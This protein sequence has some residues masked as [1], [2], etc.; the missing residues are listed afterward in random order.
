MTGKGLCINMSKNM[1]L[2]EER[3]FYKKKFYIGNYSSRK[4]IYQKLWSLEFFESVPV[5]I[6]NLITLLVSMALLYFPQAKISSL[7]TSNIHFWKMHLIKLIFIEKKRTKD[8]VWK[9][10]LWLKKFSLRCLFEYNWSFSTNIKTL[11]KM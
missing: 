9:N 11:I 2:M 7:K 4:K 5:R 1:F 6:K 3:Y 10:E 8:E